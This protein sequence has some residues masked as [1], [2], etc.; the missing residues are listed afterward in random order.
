MQIYYLHIVFF[1]LYV[2][3]CVNLTYSG[4]SRQLLMLR[5]RCHR[6]KELFHLQEKNMREKTRLAVTINR[7]T[8]HAFN[9]NA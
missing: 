3:Y 7:Q 4:Y 8:V 5:S 2:G 1:V 9:M 6:R